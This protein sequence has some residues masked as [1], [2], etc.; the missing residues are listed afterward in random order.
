MPSQSQRPSKTLKA[1][2]R[3]ICASMKTQF[4]D[5]YSPSASHS[6]LSHDRPKAA[7]KTMDWMVFSLE[8]QM[9]HIVLRAWPTTQTG[10]IILTCS[11]IFLATKQMFLLGW[12]AS[13]P[14]LKLPQN[15]SK[16][17][18]SDISCFLYLV[19]GIS[20]MNVHSGGSRKCLQNKASVET[21]QKQ[22]QHSQ[23]T[24][25][26]DKGSSDS[27]RISE[28]YHPACSK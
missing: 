9:D 21:F 2:K 11:C 22:F 17:W 3:H 18:S 16:V 10:G 25:P 20:L 7:L 12:E 14:C 6:E 4:K 8:Q 28:Q 26:G 13:L 23:N 1:L 5:N 19:V 24:K 27:P 15:G